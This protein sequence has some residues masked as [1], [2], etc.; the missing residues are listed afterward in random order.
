MFYFAETLIKS[1]DLKEPLTIIYFNISKFV[2]DDKNTWDF[3][4]NLI[5]WKSDL[6]IHAAPIAECLTQYPNPNFA[7]PNYFLHKC[8][9]RPT[10]L[11]C[12]QS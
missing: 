4:L 10:H 11:L 1:T 2:W 7:F 8:L 9:P 3:S 12:K 6:I 5:K